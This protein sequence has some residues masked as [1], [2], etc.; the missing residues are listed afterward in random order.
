MTEEFNNQTTEEIVEDNKESRS[1]QRIKQ[2]SDK[3]E[4]TAKERDKLEEL[5]VKDQEKIT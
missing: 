4:S 1:Q 2:L 3:V 5:R